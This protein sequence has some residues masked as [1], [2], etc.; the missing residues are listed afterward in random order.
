[1]CSSERYLAKWDP[2]VPAPIIVIIIVVSSFFF[3]VTRM[4]LGY[5]NLNIY[6]KI[7]TIIEKKYTYTQLF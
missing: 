3:P 7:T 1:M 5:F 6:R 2:S 4:T